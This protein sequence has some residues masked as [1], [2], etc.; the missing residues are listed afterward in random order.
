MPGRRV[1]R[2]LRRDS[3]RFGLTLNLPRVHAR[4]A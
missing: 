4:D 3:A 1:R 2:D